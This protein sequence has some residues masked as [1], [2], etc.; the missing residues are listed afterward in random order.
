MNAG[1]INQMKSYI[2]QMNVAFNQISGRSGFGGND[3]LVLLKQGI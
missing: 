3:R 1:R 2:L